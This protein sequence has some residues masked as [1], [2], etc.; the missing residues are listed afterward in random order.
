MKKHKNKGFKRA[1]IIWVLSLAII[2]SYKGFNAYATNEEIEKITN[3][4][5]QH[6]I[7]YS[8]DDLYRQDYNGCGP[9]SA[10]V[11]RILLN[12]DVDSLQVS[13]A[14]PLRIP[15]RKSTIPEGIEKYLRNQWISVSTP[16]L[17]HLSD[18][19]KLNYLRYHVS[20]DHPII[21]LV[22]LWWYQHF[23]TLLGYNTKRMERYIYDSIEKRGEEGHTLDRNGERTGNRTRTDR[24]LL[25][26]WNNWGAFGFYDNY[27]LI[28]SK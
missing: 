19:E 7:S 5:N 23:F 4:P 22:D 25:K 20:Q 16:K 2:Y 26:A 11:M 9:F 15:R 18:E 17:E 8:S 12:E 1:L 6:E 27:A 3:I 28:A 24:D 13:A 14:M 10:A 21:L